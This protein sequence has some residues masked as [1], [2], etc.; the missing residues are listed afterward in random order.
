MKTTRMWLVCSANHMQVVAIKV[1]MPIPWFMPESIYPRSVTCSMSSTNAFASGD[2]RGSTCVRRV[3]A[4]HRGSGSD[5]RV[6]GAR[7][8][9]AASIVGQHPARIEFNR[10]SYNYIYIYRLIFPAVERNALSIF[11]PSRPNSGGLQEADAAHTRPGTWTPRDTGRL[12][13]TQ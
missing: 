9:T 7:V 13:S 2:A 8:V 3:M 4:G 11:C 5:Q 1:N 10:L 12:P 6:Q